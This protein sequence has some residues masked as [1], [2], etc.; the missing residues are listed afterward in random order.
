MSSLERWRGLKDLLVD[1]V[2]NGSSA[3]EKVHLATAGR[4][5]SVLEL[6]PGVSAPARIVHVVHD[7]S[8]KTTYATIR[9][10]TQV[11]GAGLELGL[12]AAEERPQRR[13][14]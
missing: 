11:V 5:F 2:V 9:A 7:L 10:V 14:G 8:A 4:T 6:V 1:A 13:A 3:V 12:S